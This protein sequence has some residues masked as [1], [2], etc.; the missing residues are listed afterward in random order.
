MNPF[1]YL[2]AIN[3]TKEDIMVDDLSEKG[4][5]S[6]MVNRGLSYFNDTILMANE[7]NI[8]HHLDKKLQFKFYINII[9]KR[10]R[11]SKWFKPETEDDVN[12]VKEYYGYSKEKAIQVLKLFSKQQINELNEKVY[13]GGRK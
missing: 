12:V 6:F 10:K 11:F 8:N 13:K 4:Y 9:R 3:D 7:M 1:E 2:K 5:N